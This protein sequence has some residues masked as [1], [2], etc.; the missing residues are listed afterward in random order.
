[1]DMAKNFPCGVLVGGKDSHA[2]LDVLPEY[3]TIRVETGQW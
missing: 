2:M 3:L 1:M